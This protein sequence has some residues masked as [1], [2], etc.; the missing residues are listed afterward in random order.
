M[1]GQHCST[2]SFFS[3]ALHTLFCL[4]FTTSLCGM[5][6]FFR[7]WC[8]WTQRDGVTC[9]WPPSTKLGYT[10]FN[11]EQSVFRTG[12][13]ETIYWVAFMLPRKIIAGIQSQDYPLWDQ[14]ET[15]IMLGIITPLSSESVTESLKQQPILTSQLLNCPW[16]SKCLLSS[17]SDIS[18]NG[19]YLA[20][21]LKKLRLAYPK[22]QNSTVFLNRKY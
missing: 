8:N 4:V 10:G 17:R 16:G 9:L 1:K 3:G 11:P 12:T 7:W 22:G 15:S 20:E 19:V 5:H 2:A 14:S 18:Q 13:L 21:L 6:R